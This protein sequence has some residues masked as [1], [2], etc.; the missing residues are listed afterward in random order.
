MKYFVANTL[1]ESIVLVLE[2]WGTEIR[3]SPGQRVEVVAEGPAGE[4]EIEHGDR[5]ITLYG[6]EGSVM[7]A[8]VDEARI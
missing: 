5:R 7:Y 6:W 1:G 2:P 3:V 8:L 4:L